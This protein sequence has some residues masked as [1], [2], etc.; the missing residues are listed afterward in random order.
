M[1]TSADRETATRRG[2]VVATVGHVAIAV[3][4]AFA[5]VDQAPDPSATSFWL[6]ACFSALGAGACAL[7]WAAL[8]ASGRTRALI[9]AAVLLLVASV[10]PVVV[11]AG[12][13]DG[14][15]WVVLPALLLLWDGWLLLWASRL[16]GLTS[17][18]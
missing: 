4:A 13:E 3:V 5:A 2:F 14:T 9:G 8:R 6:L 15:T 7:G 16:T 1:V 17:K 10:V 11:A 12:R 18:A